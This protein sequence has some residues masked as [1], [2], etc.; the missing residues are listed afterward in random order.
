MYGDIHSFIA[1]CR[2]NY[3][4]SV[5]SEALIYIGYAMHYIEPKRPSYTQARDGLLEH[6][7]QSHLRPLNVTMSNMG[8][9]TGYMHCCCSTTTYFYSYRLKAAG[10]PCTCSV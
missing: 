1:I 6:Y 4:D 7:R 5:E 10:A 2:A 9:D 3:V 8:V